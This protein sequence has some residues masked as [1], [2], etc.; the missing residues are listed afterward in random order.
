MV[1]QMNR[2]LLAVAF[3]PG[4]GA[5]ALAA[6]MFGYVCT[7]SRLKVCYQGHWSWPRMIVIGLLVA[8]GVTWA[9]YGKLTR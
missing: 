9:V 4:L 1:R 3:L 5:G 7:D 6:R 2:K 8:A